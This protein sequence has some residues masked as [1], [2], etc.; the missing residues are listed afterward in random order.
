M[1]SFDVVSLFIKV[2]MDEAK[3]AI[4]KML[5]NNDSIDLRT[6]VSPSEVYRLISLCL[7]STYFRLKNERA[8]VLLALTMIELTLTMTMNAF[9][10]VMFLS[11]LQL[12]RSLSEMKF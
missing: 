4:S 6:I 9:F 11:F 2:P 7:G 5:E 12:H 10:S 1:V 8:L 3:H